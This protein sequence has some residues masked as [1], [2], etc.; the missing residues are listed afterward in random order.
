MIAYVSPLW[1]GVDLARAAALDQLS[2]GRALGHVAYL[3]VW[4]VVGT[5]VARRRFAVRLQK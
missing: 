2:A 4:L 3:L 1:H 5:V